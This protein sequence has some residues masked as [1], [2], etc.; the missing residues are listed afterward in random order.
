M[1]EQYIKKIHF[2]W[3][4]VLNGED[5]DVYEAGKNDVV[6]IKKTIEGYQIDFSSGESE[7]ICNPNRIFIENVKKNGFINCGFK[8]GEII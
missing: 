1:I 7:V 2:N 5:Y 3:R 8:T 4:Q 6:L